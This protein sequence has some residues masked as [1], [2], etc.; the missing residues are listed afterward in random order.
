MVL[1]KGSVSTPRVVHSIAIITPYSFL[2]FLRGRGRHE[3]LPTSRVAASTAFRGLS[4]GDVPRSVVA[5]VGNVDVMQT[6]YDR[7]FLF[8][9]FELI[10]TDS[11]RIILRSY[12]KFQTLP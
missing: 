4:V 11:V 3:Q 10:V 12:M 2:I 9:F 1:T 5:V 8:W 6:K 7:F